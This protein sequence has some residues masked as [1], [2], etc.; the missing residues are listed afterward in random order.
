MLAR[1]CVIVTLGGAE[2]IHVGSSGYVLAGIV[3]VAA[4]VGVGG[5]ATIRF[6]RL[7]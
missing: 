6:R 7:P 5:Y 3:V 2:A 4:G 1:A